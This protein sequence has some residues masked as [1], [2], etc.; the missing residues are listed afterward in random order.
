MMISNRLSPGDRQRALAR[1]FE[2]VALG[3]VGRLVRRKVPARVD[4]GRAIRCEDTDGDRRPV[5]LRTYSLPVAGGRLT[6]ADCAD[7]G[8]PLS[9]QKSTRCRPIA[10][11]PDRRFR[12]AAWRRRQAGP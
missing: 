9:G 11:S 8:V 7:A 2:V 10:G 1:Q 6:A 4:N 3:I 12:G 5:R